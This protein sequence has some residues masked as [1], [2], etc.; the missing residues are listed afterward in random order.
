MRA[1][2]PLATGAGPRLG[3][4]SIAWLVAIA[5]AA[6]CLAL[7]FG[8]GLGFVARQWG[9]PEYSH[10]WLIPVVTLVVLW[11]RRRAILT[12]RPDGSWLGCGL[13]AIGLV[14]L[15]LG[16]MAF[17]QRA[18]FV[19]L[20]VVLAGL[21]L[22]AL[23][24]RAMR[25]AWLPLLF[26]YFALPLPGSIYV[27][28]STSL[29]FVS[30]EL[31]AGMLRLLGVSVYLDGNIIDLGTYQLQV[32]EACSGLR[33]LFPLAS[34]GFLCAWLFNA[35]FWA[36]AIVLLSTV[37]ITVLTNSARI[38]MTGLFVE[39]GSI[40]LAEGFMHLFEGWVIFIVA[41]LVLFALMWLLARV[42]GNNR[43]VLDLLDFDR[44]TAE[45]DAA[46]A[47]A[48]TP[49]RVPAPFAA[50][51]GLILAAVAAHGPLTDRVQLIP[52]RPGL[53]TFPLR[54]EGW[55]GLPIPIGDQQVLEQLGADDYLLAD[56]ARDGAPAPVN[57][58]VAYYDHQLGTAAIHSPKDCLPGGGW[59]YVSLESLD[60]PVT[61]AD[62]RSFSL[63]RGLIAKG[64]EQMV[65]YYWVEIRGRKLTNDTALKIYNLWDSFRMRRSDGAL[66]RLMS[67]VAPGEDVTAADRRL[68]DFLVRSYPILEAHVGA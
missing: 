48:T 59:E 11:S 61:A 33:Y 43:H 15:L 60:A 6:I 7:L 3:R 37:P 49:R 35:P 64:R 5:L 28:L 1:T 39:H 47:R 9:D 68:Q 32:A 24:F 2:A 31:G 8:N 25:F 34:F 16:E 17:V 18:G 63:N 21:G 58:W 67:P 65:I 13:V 56:F 54:I 29:Q 42:L 27:P 45:P 62:G 41:L 38:A 30:S 36:R 14:G 4:E 44:L 51:L 12:T 22:A 19:M 50:S 66:V 40:E 55:R 23:G 10:G 57:L 20:P 52:Q 46:G 53:V 26:L